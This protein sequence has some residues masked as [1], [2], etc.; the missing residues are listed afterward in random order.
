MRKIRNEKE[1]STLSWFD[2]DPHFEHLHDTDLRKKNVS[3][4][5]M[6]SFKILK[7]NSM[8]SNPVKMF[9]STYRLNDRN[10]IFLYK[11]MEN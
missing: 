4:M 10:S 11:E 1:V 8:I 6:Y 3:L 5:E 2:F 9:G 7:R